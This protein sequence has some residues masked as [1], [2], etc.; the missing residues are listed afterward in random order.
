[1]KKMNDRLPIFWRH[2]E[3][4]SVGLR[5]FWHL[6]SIDDGTFPFN[7]LLLHRI[8]SER[9]YAAWLALESHNRSSHPRR[10]A[11]S[12]EVL[13]HTI[14]SW[15]QARDDEQWASKSIL[16]FDPSGSCS[17]SIGSDITLQHLWVSQL[18]LC[19]CGCDGRFRISR[20]TSKVQ[21]HWFTGK[22]RESHYNKYFLLP[23][24]TLETC[25]RTLQMLSCGQSRRPFIGHWR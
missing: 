11:F 10:L 24:R 18:H 3:P 12:T 23:G 9:K 19:W 17:Q 5:S 4:H 1:M 22:S 7:H 25:I 8:K 16:L 20:P 2:R 14:D 6:Q 13:Y 15:R 21:L